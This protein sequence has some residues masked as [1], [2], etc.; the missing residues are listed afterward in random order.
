MDIGYERKRILKSDSKAFSLR[1]SK[2]R[3]IPEEVKWGRQ[4]VDQVGQGE[5][6]S[7]M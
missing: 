3:V 4:G 6:N 7:E 1:I 5:K 2:T